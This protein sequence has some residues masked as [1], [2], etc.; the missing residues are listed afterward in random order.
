MH[1]A[2][3]VHVVADPAHDQILLQSAAVVSSAAAATCASQCAA[4]SVASVPCHPPLSLIKV[5]PLPSF[6]VTN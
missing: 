4:T 2:E 5:P 1:D 3:Q 6:A